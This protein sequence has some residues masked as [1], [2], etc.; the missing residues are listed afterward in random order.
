MLLSADF[1]LELGGF[2]LQAQLTLD[3]GVLVLF[4]PSGAGKSLTIS[5]LAG[6]VAPT[7]GHIRIANQT[8]F[9]SEAGVQV[10]TRD[11]HIGYVPQH[12]SLFPFRD[13]AE[14]VAFGLPK[15]R[16]R[17][18]DPEVVA[19]LE[20]LELSH[21]ASARPSSLS[22]GERQRVA[23]ARALAVRPKLLLLDEPFASIDRA[24]RKRVRAV[25]RRA[26]EHHQIPAVLVTHDPAEALELGD[27]LVLFE[28][29]RTVDAG[30]PREL[31]AS[32]E[33]VIEGAVAERVEDGGLASLTLRGGTVRGPASALH[34]EDGRLSL[35]VPL[36]DDES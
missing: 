6:L 19:L 26:L 32:R 31:L 15:A 27:H 36:P 3:G 18:D 23:F 1:S 20:E 7:R 11:R 29:G 5:A 4:G 35:V 8:V 25:L 10:P 28:R 9:D 33:I 34:T 14:N 13:V 21:L 30:S 12:H 24:G 22:G 2:A 16:R 17:R